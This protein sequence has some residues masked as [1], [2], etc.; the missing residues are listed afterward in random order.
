[1]VSKVV[2]HSNLHLIYH[3]SLAKTCRC[4]SSKKMPF[5]RQ[6]ICSLVFFFHIT[7]LLACTPLAC[8]LC[9]ISPYCE[10]AS[11]S[12]FTAQSDGLLLCC[13]K[14][15]FREPPVLL[16][17]S[18][19][20]ECQTLCST[21]Q[22]CSVSVSWSLWPIGR[23]WF[24]TDSDPVQSCQHSPMMSSGGLVFFQ[25]MLCHLLRQPLF[26]PT[27][28]KHMAIKYKLLVQPWLWFDLTFDLIWFDLIFDKLNLLLSETLSAAPPG[29]F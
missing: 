18:S 9:I 24:V 4:I 19:E 12:L 3:C 27:Y 17:T 20:W 13:A 28:M 21:A 8:V 6:Q 10:L 1:M 22:V 14:M 16:I 29:S 7:H 5:C 26:F 11:L 25:N 15:L 23:L 2:P